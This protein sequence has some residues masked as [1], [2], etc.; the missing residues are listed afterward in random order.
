MHQW[1]MDGGETWS[2]ATEILPLGAA[3]GGQNQLVK[4]SAGTLHVILATGSGVYS[5]AGDGA[6]WGPPEPIDT[7]P[8][9]P[10]GQTIT[11][12]QGNHVNVAYYDRVG[13][14]RVWYSSRQVNAPHIARKP[15]PTLELAIQVPANTT[16]EEAPPVQVKNTTTLSDLPNGTS[17][18]VLSGGDSSIIGA[19]TPVVI[20]VFVAFIFAVRAKR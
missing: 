7:R 10:H 11:T 19:I 5:V 2:A 13:G 9:D 14:E 15:M 17:A 18:P 3:F 8:I 6:Q 1:S 4:D 16:K 20:L 12:C